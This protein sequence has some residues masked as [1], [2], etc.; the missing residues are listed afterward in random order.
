[1]DAAAKVDPSKPF[2]PFSYTPGNPDT[3][4]PNGTVSAPTNGQVLTSSPIT[5]SGNATDDLSVT[6]V[7]VAIRNVTTSQWWNG[8]A[9]QTAIFQHEAILTAP[10]TTSTAWSLRGC[11][12]GAGSYAIQVTAVDGVGKVDATKPWVPFSYASPSRRRGRAE[13]HRDVA[14]P[15]SGGAA[16]PRTFTGNATD[17]VSVTNVRVAIRNVTT[18]QWWNGTSWGTTFVNLRRR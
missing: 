10:G 3:A 4:A 15:E 2:V 7:R 5:F 13:R 12:R 14:D 11:R 16:R 8:S 17:D 9:W 1:M 18:T 6:N